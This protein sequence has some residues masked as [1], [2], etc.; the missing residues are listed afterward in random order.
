M[1]DYD[2]T[3][4]PAALLGGAFCL[5]LIA[6]PFVLIAMFLLACDSAGNGG[7]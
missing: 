4:W 6:L 7:W 2:P 3:D 5:F 1:P